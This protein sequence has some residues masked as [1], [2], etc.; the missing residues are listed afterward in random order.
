MAQATLVEI[1]DFFEATSSEFTAEW[2][3]LDEEDRNY[4]KTAVGA[5]LTKE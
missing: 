3:E 2:K 4:F 5:E 1:R